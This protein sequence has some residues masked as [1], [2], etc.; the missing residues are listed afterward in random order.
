MTSLIAFHV[1]VFSNYISYNVLWNSIPAF[2]HS[3]FIS[4]LR[5]KILFLPAK[6]LAT[7]NLL[8]VE[9]RWFE[10]SYRVRGGQS[11]LW[12]ASETYCNLYSII[13]QEMRKVDIKHQMLFLVKTNHFCWVLY[14]TV[15]HSQFLFHIHPSY[16]FKVSICSRCNV[17]L[18][19][20]SFCKVR[21]NKI[22]FHAITIRRKTVSSQPLV[23]S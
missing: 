17:V 3:W 9:I 18:I 15:H 11:W 13:C 22:P 5:P 12:T 21:S 8:R 14:G 4:N 1:Y 16:F 7:N 6:C 20:Q 23:G 10:D 2:L 19:F